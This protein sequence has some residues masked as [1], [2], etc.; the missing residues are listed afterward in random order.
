MTNVTCLRLSDA[1]VICRVTYFQFTIQ[2]AFLPYIGRQAAPALPHTISFDTQYQTP[3]IAENLG[4]YLSC[5]EHTSQGKDFE[6][7]L[8]VKM[9]TR[10]PVHSQPNR[11]YRT[12]K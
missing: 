10:H 6:L 11:C 5:A 7:L 3:D 9:E 4:R 12:P 8:M 1:S 2:S